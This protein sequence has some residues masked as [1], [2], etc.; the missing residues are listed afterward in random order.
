ML[1]GDD[2]QHDE[3]GP[4]ATTATLGHGL[5][6]TITSDCRSLVAL[7][8]RR[9]FRE[10]QF[11]RKMYRM[12]RAS[13]GR[14]IKP[15]LWTKGFLSQR[16][17]LYPFARF[18]RRLFLSDWEIEKRLGQVN[19]K[20][21]MALL[22]NK[23]LFHLVLARGGLEN[24]APTLV[25]MLTAGQFRSLSPFGT[26]GEAVAAFG[27]LVCKPVGG[28]GGAD[29]SVIRGADR[30]E[31]KGLF[32]LEAF[33]EQHAYASHI[34][35]G[36]LNTIRVVTMTD[37]GGVP[38]VAGAA[39]R[40]GCAASAP[41][42]NF[43]RGGISA[44]VDDTTG[45]LSAGRSNPGRHADHVHEVHPDSGERIAGVQVPMWD[46]AK[47]LALALARL[48]PGLHHIGWDLCITADGPRV[49]EGNSR[50][51]NP[52]LIQA[53]RPLMLDPK[54]RDFLHRHGVLSVRRA[55]QLREL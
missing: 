46:E 52:N 36:S 26:I 31:E 17:T 32:L 21:A 30:P 14:V 20:A 28:S 35:S 13:N 47:A 39:H 9:L 23:L 15:S 2:D 40:F 51:A 54:V 7:I 43:K 34:F 55:R 11:V 22:D 27:A 5:V 45:I 29:I 1:S 3:L 41:V 53:H 33:I 25:G 50:L 48:F 37:L 42:D 19:D 18:D 44:L 12:E 16:A 8:I 38:F 6:A 49:I 10:F 4:L 24:T